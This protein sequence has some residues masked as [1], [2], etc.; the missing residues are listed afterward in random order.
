VQKIH[1]ARQRLAA[2][3]SELTGLARIVGDNRALKEERGRILQERLRAFW[4]C[5]NCSS[6]QRCRRRRWAALR[7]RGRSGVVQPVD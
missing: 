2:L 3:D 1:E 7:I 6:W 4:N 5:C